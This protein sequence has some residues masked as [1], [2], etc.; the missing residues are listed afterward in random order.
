MPPTPPHPSYKSDTPRPSPR[1]N[2]TRRVPHP[3]LIGQV[4]PTRAT[5]ASRPSRGAGRSQSLVAFQPGSTRRDRRPSP[6]PSYS[7]P[8]HSTYCTLASPRPPR[9]TLVYLRGVLIPS[10]MCGSLVVVIER[11]FLSP[12]PILFCLPLTPRG[13]D[14]RQKVDKKLTLTAPRCAIRC[15]DDAERFHDQYATVRARVPPQPR[16]DRTRRVLC[17]RTDQTLQQL[18]RLG[19]SGAGEKTRFC[20]CCWGAVMRLSRR[21]PEQKSENATVRGK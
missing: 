17:P 14:F 18:P 12:A 7:P 1:T 2:R 21:R 6:P 4:C 20:F 9:P 5:T 10:Y 3:V 19:G 11:I 16:T 13:K 8:Y 15:A